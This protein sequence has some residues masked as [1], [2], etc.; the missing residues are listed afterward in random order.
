MIG[1]RGTGSGAYQYTGDRGPRC[2]PNVVD[3]PALVEVPLGPG[4]DFVAILAAAL[5]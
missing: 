3:E 2:S 4:D 1:R 5:R